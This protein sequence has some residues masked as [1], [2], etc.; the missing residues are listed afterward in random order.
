MSNWHDGREGEKPKCGLCQLLFFWYGFPIFLWENPPNIP[1]FHWLTGVAFLL[2][3]SKSN[4]L[5]ASFDYRKYGPS[6]N[7]LNIA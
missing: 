1:T 2:Q 7:L 3:E 4:R 5:G 6:K